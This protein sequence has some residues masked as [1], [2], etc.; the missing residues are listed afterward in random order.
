MPL[1]L[2]LPL[3]IFA[4]LF[5]FFI[6]AKG[7]T[8]NW[9]MRLNESIYLILISLP[10]S[11]MRVFTLQFNFPNLS[12]HLFGIMAFLMIPLLYVPAL[13]LYFYRVK[14]CSG[15]NSASFTAIAVSLVLMSDLVL[16]LVFVAFFPNMR[17]HWTMTLTEYPIPIIL[18]LLLHCAAASA[19]TVLFMKSTKN[20]RKSLEHNQR[21]Q[22]IFLCASVSVLAV[23]TTVLFIFY[24]QEDFLS[25]ESWSWDIL[26]AFLLIYILLLGALLHAKTLN[27]KYEQ[28]RTDAE[29]KDLK[30]YTDM[31]EQQYTAIRKFKHDYQNILS[32]MDSFFT[33]NDWAGLM[34]YYTQAIKPSSEII[35]K[36]DFALESLQ[37]IKVT[38]IKS[39]LT[40]KLLAA[41][42]MHMD[43]TTSFEAPD[44]IH[45]IPIDSVSLVRMLGII[46]DN[47]IEE[48]VALS[49]GKLSVACFQ[50]NESLTFVVQN[51][52][53]T[54]IPKLHKLKQVGF[55]SK[56]KGRGYGLT[57]LAEIEASKP[58]V[59]LSTTIEANTFTQQLTINAKDETQKWY[60]S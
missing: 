25:Q 55:S 44:E 10:L 9:N 49:G 21:L 41:Q 13:F 33:E 15:K 36:D 39:I 28:E 12:I 31:L 18:H 40:V 60:M 53:R 46:L 4:H 19:L 27:Q 3:S 34:Q 11:V 26:A 22:N 2:N 59:T 6:V 20:L 16:D 24:T 17:L 29:Y 57:I 42:N 45:S 1:L 14:L 47:A 8:G 48:L 30:Y 43:I 35:A 5:F 51:T 58:N 7:L 52:C 23:L 54:D 37:K 50:N 32:S 56:E 38:E